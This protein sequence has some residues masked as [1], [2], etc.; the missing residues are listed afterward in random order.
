M[1]FGKIFTLNFIEYF[2]FDQVIKIKNQCYRIRD[3]TVFAI[4]IQIS[5]KLIYGID[6]NH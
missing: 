4:V 1:D 5:V 2:L 6:R 3:V